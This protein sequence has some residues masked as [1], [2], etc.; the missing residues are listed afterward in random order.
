MA[1][2][3][4]TAIG[5][6]QP[7]IVAGV[8]AV[9]LEQGCNLEDTEMAVL[10]GHFAMMLVVTG[11][12]TLAAPDLEAALGAVAEQLDLVVTVRPI[13]EAAPTAPPVQQWSVSVYGA[14]QPGIVHRVATVLADAGANIVGL[15]TRVIGDARRPVYAM[16]L[17]VTAPEGV[18]EDV[19]AARLSQEAGG[20]GVECTLHPADAEIL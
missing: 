12:D 9:L 13:E 18:E 15:E 7:G 10:R 8:T 5:I 17:E 6:D 16:L 2:F 1:H 19:L 3:A 11:P 14:D 4:V 20:L